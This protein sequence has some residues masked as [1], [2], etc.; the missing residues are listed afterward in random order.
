MLFDYFF[1][2]LSNNNKLN[3]KFKDNE[4]PQ[5]GQKNKPARVTFSFDDL[6]R[7]KHQIEMK[8][9]RGHRRS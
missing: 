7:G 6:K 1:L 5:I 4:L 2:I 3:A 8:S 9:W